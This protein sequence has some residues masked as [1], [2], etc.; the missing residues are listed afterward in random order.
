MN[1]ALSHAP[2]PSSRLERSQLAA[3]FFLHAHAGGMWS[4]AF[5]SVLKAHGLERIV[6]YAFACSSIAAFISPLFVGTLADRHL[7]ADRLLRWLSCGTAGLLALTYVAIERGWGAVPVLVC[8]QVQSLVSAPMWG[9]ST[10]IVLSRL[11]DAQREFG[12]IR[13]WATYGWMAAGW[14][15]SYVLVADASTRSGFAAAAV[16]LAVSAF[17]FTLPS[18]P[19]LEKAG[20]STWR[21]LLGGGALKL[22]AHPEHRVVFVTAGLFSIPLAAFFP[23]TP[24]QLLDAGFAHPAAAMS[25]G[26]ITE[27]LALYGL[28]R[29][30][31][32]AR[33][34]WI[35]LTGIGAGLVRFGCFALGSKAA[36]IAGIVLHGLSFTLFFITAQ[37]YLEMRVAPE[38]RARAQG[39]VT[40]MTV[41]FG[42]LIGAL[43]TGWWRAACQHAGVTDWTRFWLGLCAAIAAV[44][45]FFAVAYRGVKRGA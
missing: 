35:F 21:D 39:L 44:F 23:F 12:P 45:V 33:L 10:T 3:L 8:L 7:P 16:L 38:L 37:L 25:L 27:V 32:G 31:R 4:V 42:N 5:S 29:V 22:L 14:V 13:V 26:Q 1:G 15:T 30:L 17:T 20:V 2:M 28:A 43:G 41:G 9:L 40:L 11:G 24:L 6:P 34:K 18:V 36:L 19:P